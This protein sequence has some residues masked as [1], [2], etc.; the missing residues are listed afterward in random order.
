M[1]ILFIF[2]SFVGFNILADLPTTEGINIVQGNQSYYD[3]DYDNNQLY[4]YVEPPLN[5][6]PEYFSGFS[7]LS[8]S[9]I[10]HKARNADW[11]GISKRTIDF[12]TVDVDQIIARVI[13]PTGLVTQFALTLE[14]EVIQNIGWLLSG[15]IW[16]FLV[17]ATTGDVQTFISSLGFLLGPQS[18]ATTIFRSAWA[19]MLEIISRVVAA[20]VI[21]GFEPTIRG[22]FTVTLRDIGDFIFNPLV[23]L[24]GI[25]RGVLIIAFI[26]AAAPGLWLFAQNVW[27]TIR[28][29]TIFGRKKRS[30]DTLDDVLNVFPESSVED[31][32]TEFTQTRMFKDWI[33]EM[34]ESKLNSIIE[35]IKEYNF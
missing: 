24:L 22:M 12:S 29:A 18:L 2:L 28:S 26:F 8:W 19:R 25:G 27:P 34:F 4:R 35:S 1:S 14:L 20:M 33:P 7:D 32:Y 16:T 5:D 30:V 6:E 23:V 10:V 31:Y 15:V 11:Y 21:Y 9:N 3:Y 13:S 17:G